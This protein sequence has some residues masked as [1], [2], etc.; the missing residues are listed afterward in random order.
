MSD[1]AISTSVQIQIIM[2]VCVV[3]SAKVQTHFF[4]QLVE[5]KLN[6]VYARNL[7][8]CGGKCEP[9]LTAFDGALPTPVVTK[10]GAWDEQLV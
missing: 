7:E 10:R 4:L 3:Y 9:Q 1:S 6:T 5:S 2:C 8:V